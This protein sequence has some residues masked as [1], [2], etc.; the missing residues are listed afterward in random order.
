M[1]IIENFPMRSI[2]V[3][4]NGVERVLLFQANE[5][6]FQRGIYVSLQQVGAKLDCDCRAIPGKYEAVIEIDEK[7]ADEFMD[8]V[9]GV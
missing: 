8:K 6:F 2:H 3:I 5:E 4:L 9:E 7:Y 1:K